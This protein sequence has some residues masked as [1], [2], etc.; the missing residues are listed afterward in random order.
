MT[1]F[2]GLRSKTYAYL[3]DGF[4]EEKRNKV[5]RTPKI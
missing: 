2:F 5:V 4:K 3:I 1:K